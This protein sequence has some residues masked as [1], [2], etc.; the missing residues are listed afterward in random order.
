MSL[1]RALRRRLS[2]VPS[3]VQMI[4]GRQ[5]I[6]IRV[7]LER[8]LSTVLPGRRSRFS[9][10]AGIGATR[11]ETMT[12][13]LAVLILVRR[14]VFDAEQPQTFGDIDLWRTSEQAPN[15]TELVPADAMEA[16]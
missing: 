1:V 14:R 16:S 13:F 10:V 8:A 11:E 5:R 2:T 6:P 3:P 15:L 7:M 4:Q 9:D 12:A